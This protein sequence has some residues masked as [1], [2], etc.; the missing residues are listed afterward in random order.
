MR[1]VFKFMLLY[2][3]CVFIK[4]SISR[5]CFLIPYIVFVFVF[6]LYSLFLFFLFFIMYL[7][8]SP[9]T[10][11]YRILDEKTGGLLIDSGDWLA[12]VPAMDYVA[13]TLE[14]RRASE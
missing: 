14:V 8:F 7:P 3:D 2:C 6:P 10:I 4:V 9:E 11:L 1:L 13:A 5:A 12:N